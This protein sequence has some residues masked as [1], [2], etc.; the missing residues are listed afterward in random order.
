[1]GGEQKRLR[2]MGREILIRIGAVMLL[3][4]SLTGGVIASSGLLPL[5]GLEEKGAVDDQSFLLVVGGLYAVILWGG[6]LCVPD[7]VPPAGQPGLYPPPCLGGVPVPVC[8]RPL[9][10]GCPIAQLGRELA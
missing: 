8:V 9:C 4:V 7:S 5:L 2:W 10:R 6:V 3:A 1:M